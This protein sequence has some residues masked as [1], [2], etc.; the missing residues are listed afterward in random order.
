MRYTEIIAEKTLADVGVRGG[1]FYLAVQGQK[2]DIPHFLQTGQIPGVEGV[3]ATK[4]I[5]AEFSPSVGRDIFLI[6]P[7]EDTL[8]LNKM[9]R[10]GYDNAEALV[11]NNSRQLSRILSIS[12]IAEQVCDNLIH[13]VLE[14][15]PGIKKIG[16]LGDSVGICNNASSIWMNL[17]KRVDLSTV[18]GYSDGKPRFD[19]V[20]ASSFGNYQ[21]NGPHLSSVDD[22]ANLYYQAA[23]QAGWYGGNFVK[24]FAPQNRNQW[25][26]LLRAGIIAQANVYSNESEWLND[27]SEFTVPKSTTV[28]LAV[29]QKYRDGPPDEDEKDIFKRMNWNKYDDERF[30]Y[31]Q[32][33]MAAFANSPYKVTV[34][35]SGK[36]SNSLQKARGQ[37]WNADFARKKAAAEAE[38]SK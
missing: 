7:A 33:L 6:M 28:L 8:R 27:R 37:R 12:N 9:H 25:A 23:K 4:N 21:A 1:K 31:Y 34:I 10:V 5:W 30:A 18:T 14:K 36:A 26:P 19:K 13:G 24:F 2:L 3:S 15:I 22:Y 17:Q 11:A 38:T 35:E 16:Q 20:D 32:S 29:P